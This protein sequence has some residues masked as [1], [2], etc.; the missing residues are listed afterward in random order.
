MLFQ[1][2]QKLEELIVDVLCRKPGLNVNELVSTINGSGVTFSMPA[3]Y[4]ELAKLNE[5]GVVLCLKHRYSLTMNW[6][7]KLISFADRL[8][9]K[10]IKSEILSFPLPEEGRSISFTFNNLFRA[11][12]FSSHAVLRL[13]SHAKEKRVYSWN[14]H[15]WFYLIQTDQEKSYIHGLEKAGG[16]FYKV[17]GGSSFLDHWT[18][19]FWKKR[20]TIYAFSDHD[21]EADRSLYYNVVDDYMSSFRLD[22]KAVQMIDDL[23]NRVKRPAELDFS[24]LARLFR[25]TFRVRFRIERSPRKAGRIRKKFGEFFSLQA[26]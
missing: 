8:D 15:A 19:Q 14:P 16:E 21:F 7:L 5:Q 12:D 13:V 3:F 20:N 2:Q 25:E 1:P 22:L 26:S 11:N 18:A 23:Y 24:T 9:A 6:V 10:Y 4:K 17:V